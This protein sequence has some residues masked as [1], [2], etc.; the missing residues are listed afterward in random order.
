MQKMLFIMLII[1]VKINESRTKNVKVILI[2]KM[3]IRTK[4]PRVDNLYKW[5][6]LMS[7]TA[8]YPADHICEVLL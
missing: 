1:S 4:V 8:T 2:K 5:Q 3:D 6:D 7:H